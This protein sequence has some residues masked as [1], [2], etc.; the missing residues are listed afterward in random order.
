LL[1]KGSCHE[2]HWQG[3]VFSWSWRQELKIRRQPR[4]HLCRTFFDEAAC[5]HL[6]V[7]CSQRRGKLGGL[8][9]LYHMST[10]NA[11]NGFFVGLPIK[12]KVDRGCTVP[13]MGDTGT[14]C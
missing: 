5:R 13:R 12:G 6:V 14:T 11:K 1:W 8:V 10:K 3:L 9:S 4:Q 7:L 2:G